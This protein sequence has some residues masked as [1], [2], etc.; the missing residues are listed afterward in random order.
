MRLLLTS[1]LS[2]GGSEVAFVVDELFPELSP[3]TEGKLV[4]SGGLSVFT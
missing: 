2:R 3:D 4:A 1:V